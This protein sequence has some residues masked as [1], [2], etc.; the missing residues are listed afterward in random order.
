MKWTKLTL[1]KLA[2]AALVAAIGFGAAPKPAEARDSFYVAY[3]NGPY[4]GS[5]YNGHRY[6]RH[7]PH[8]YYNSYGVYIGAPAYGYAYYDDPYYE[9][10][11]WRHGYRYCRAPNGRV[12]R[13]Y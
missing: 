8:G 4:Y 12:Y 1:T 10:C 3:G 11:W 2:A 7:H 9:R 6:Y 13:Y 5:Y